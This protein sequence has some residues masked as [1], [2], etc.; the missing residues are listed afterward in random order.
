MV[1]STKKW[2]S[3]GVTNPYLRAAPSFFED[4]SAIPHKI[5]FKQRDFLN[6]KG[7]TPLDK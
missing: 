1:V 3:Y 7:F 4:P 2:Q 6:K 5:R